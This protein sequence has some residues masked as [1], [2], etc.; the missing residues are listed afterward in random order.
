MT[1]IE[2]SILSGENIDVLCEAEAQTGG[3][4]CLLSFDL[5]QEIYLSE[6]H[7]SYLQNEKDS[8]LVFMLGILSILYVK[9]L[10]TQG[11]G[12]QQCFNK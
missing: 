6:P 11:L 10:G 3:Q 2:S 4:T 8:C 1:E 12:T 5:A 7:V 9:S